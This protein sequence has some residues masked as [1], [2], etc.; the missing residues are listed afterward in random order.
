M[1]IV[2]IGVALKRAASFLAALS[3]TLFA[4]HSQAAVPKRFSPGTIGLFEENL[5]QYTHDVLYRGRFENLDALVH[6]DGSISLY[7]MQ[8]HAR[9]E[10]RLMHLGAVEPVAI[11][12]HGQDAYRTN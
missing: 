4:V 1:A 8:R 2:D 11:E 9:H 10:M 5:G 6:R 7:P 3:L 12:G